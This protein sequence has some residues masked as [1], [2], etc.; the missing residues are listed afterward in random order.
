MRIASCEVTHAPGEPMLPFKTVR[1]LLPPGAKVATV[2]AVTPGQPASLRLSG[3]VEHALSP[4]T[5][6]ASIP[7]PGP[8]GPDPAIYLSEDLFPASPVEWVSVQRLSGYDVAILRV[9]PVQYRPAGGE[10]VF[11]P[12]LEVTLSLEAADPGPVLL[13]SRTSASR[14]AERVAR[15]VDNRERLEDYSPLQTAQRLDASAT[16]DYLL[17][18][19][20]NLAAAFQPLF[21]AKANTGLSVKVE[22]VENISA[23]Q[24][25]RD[26]AERIRNFIRYAHTNWGTSF[27]LLGGDTATVPCRYAYVNM[28]TLVSNPSLPT[29][30]YYAC[31]DGSWN[32]DGDTRWGEATDGETGG[33]VDLLAEVYVG[34]APVDTVQE[35]AAFVNKVVRYASGGHP[36]SRKALVVAEFLGESSSGP[37]QGGDMFTPLEPVFQDFQLTWLDDRPHTLPQWTRAQALNAINDSPHVALFNGHGDDDTLIGGNSYVRNIDTSDLDSITNQFPFLLYSVGCN[38]GQ[39]DNDKFSPDCIGEEIVKR[40]GSGAFAAILN[41]RLGWYDPRDE[42]K[43][44]GEFQLRFFQELLTRGQTNF[45]VANQLSKHGMLGQVETAGIMTYRWCYYE[46]TLLGDPHLAW[47]SAPIAELVTSHGT[48]VSW[49]KSFGWTNDF[50]AAAAADVDGDGQPAWQEYIAGTS[51]VDPA[52]ALRVSGAWATGTR[53]RLEWPAVANRHYA[54]WRANPEDADSFVLIAEGL[55]ATPP[56]NSF[57]VET[58]GNR[59][60]LFRVSVQQAP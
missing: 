31:L 35:V 38:V 50:E 8:E 28:G 41:S 15:L 57:E 59:G 39:F 34:R 12:R 29:D 32:S 36:N 22:T 10:L 6:V 46:I 51:P 48:S 16:Y 54:V 1:L 18:T 53:V 23:S 27:V 5:P 33:D 40:E 49:L 3:A 14:A 11:T 60:A 25:G 43:F 26:T 19:R 37:S 47:L 45:G 13:R 24:P 7:E 58:S 21:D 44:S 52:S 55:E 17:I 30:L 9:F 4:R 2:S 56:R 20:S 42:A